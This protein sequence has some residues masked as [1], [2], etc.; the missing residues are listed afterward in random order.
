M[1]KQG[2][3]RGRRLDR[4]HAVYSSPCVRC[5]PCQ[6]CQHCQHCQH[7]QLLTACP[8][9]IAVVP[10]RVQ[11]LS[12]C[13]ARI[14]MFF[15]QFLPPAGPECQRV[16][17]Q[18]GYFH[19]LQGPSRRARG[20][21][22]KLFSCEGT[23]EPRVY[24]SIPQ[25]TVGTIRIGGSRFWGGE[26]GIS[27]NS[28]LSRI[29]PMPHPPRMNPS[30]RPL[31][32]SFAHLRTRDSTKGV[33][34][35]LLAPAGAEAMT[36]RAK[37]YGARQA[38]SPCKPASAHDGGTSSC[39][40]PRPWPGCTALARRAPSRPSKRLRKMRRLWWPRWLARVC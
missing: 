37:V 11:I 20:G 5:L 15:S 6:P 16:C 33:G 9:L 12:S 36:G 7:C 29:T 1:Q 2:I 40:R 18:A 26:F 38:A 39:S 8:S 4:V 14:G 23:V 10:R 3:A 17:M 32:V 13:L 25:R 27:P 30:W 24:L 21:A 34:G 31:P 22:S 19:A 35:I 28:Y